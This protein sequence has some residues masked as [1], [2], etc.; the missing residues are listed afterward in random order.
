MKRYRACAAPANLLDR[1]IFLVGGDEPAIPERVVDPTDPVT[2]NLIGHRSDELCLSRHR[3]RHRGVD[4]L[5]IEMYRDRRATDGLRAERL[6]LGVLVGQHDARIADLDLGVMDLAAGILHPHDLFGAERLLVEGDGVACATQD[7]IG[8]HAVIA[9]RDRFYR[10]S[11]VG[12][13][14]VVLRLANIYKPIRVS[15]LSRSTTAMINAPF[16]FPWPRSW[17]R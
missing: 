3:A 6:Q 16:G 10:G 13:L 12:L 2:V 7:Q 1:Q 15:E 17:L 4:I 14:G 5:D 9:F 11:H 8:R